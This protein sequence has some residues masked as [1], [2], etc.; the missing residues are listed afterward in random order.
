MSLGVISPIRNKGLYS[1]WLS[2]APLATSMLTIDTSGNVGSQAIPVAAW[3]SITGT[4]SSQTD[5]QNALDAKLSLSGGTMTGKITATAT[6][7]N[8]GGIGNG[9]NGIDFFNGVIIYNNFGSVAYPAYF[10]Y[11]SSISK[12][13]FSKDT[14]L[15]WD[16]NTDPTA[17]GNSGDLAILRDAADTLAQRR[18]TNAQRLNLYGTFTDASNYIRQSL[19]FTTY[20]ST[21]HAQLAAEG[22]GTGAVRIPF[23]VTPRGTGSFILGPMPDGTATGGNARGNYAVDLQMQRTSATQVASGPNSLAAGYRATASGPDPGSC[24]IGDNVVASGSR[25]AAFNH[26][27]TASGSFSFACGQPATASGENSFAR[28]GTASGSN[29]VAFSGISAGQFSLTVGSGVETTSTAHYSQAFGLLTRAQ[30]MN[31]QVGGSHFFTYG[32]DA[33]RVTL[34]LANKTTNATPTQ[35]YLDGPTGTTLFK[36]S[37]NPLNNGKIFVFNILVLGTK[38]DGTAIAMYQRRVVVKNVGG[39]I[40]LAGTVETIGTDYEDNASTDVAITADDANDSLKIEVT[41]VASETWRWIAR[42]DGVEV[43]Y[44]T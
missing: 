38:S 9:T 14:Q 30:R 28:A 2:A 44:G 40:S 15:H 5:L 13:K 18:G 33:Q 17:T 34:S 21:V 26:N 16:S 11:G 41:G 27:T 23:V 19:S 25:A 20:S 35:L 42:A 24:A 43:A 6:G 32:G 31:E 37:A 29:S 4:L 8:S 39:T 12:L 10:C 36:V 22:A 7:S 3:G 1:D